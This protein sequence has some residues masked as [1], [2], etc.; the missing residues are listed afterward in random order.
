MN[1]GVYGLYSPPSSPTTGSPPVSPSRN[2]VFG[3]AES[4]RGLQINKARMGMS[5]S[6][7]MSPPSWGL[8]MG[9]VFGSPHSPSTLRP[10]FTSLPTTPIRAPTRSGLTAFDIWETCSEEEPVMERVESGRKL[11][12]KIYE[13]LSKENSLDRVES[14]IPGSY[15]GWVSELLQ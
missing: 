15:F 3:L 12:E 6:L 5:P 7:S 4:M 13:K 2:S 14:G 1:A 11:R 10:L 9:S 8:K